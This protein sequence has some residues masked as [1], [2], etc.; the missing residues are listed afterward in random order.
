MLI[1]SGN[2][3]SFWPS[4]FGVHAFGTCRDERIGSGDST[5]ATLRVSTT[6][7]PFVG[8]MVIKYSTALSYLKTGVLISVKFRPVGGAQLYW[9]PVPISRAL[10]CLATF[11]LTVTVA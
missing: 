4:P 7:H 10:S 11:G 6:L 9:E 5:T 2:S 1:V 8:L 3:L